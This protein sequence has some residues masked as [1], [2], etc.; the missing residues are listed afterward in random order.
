M[1]KIVMLITV[2][3]LMIS[4]TV[5]A[6]DTTT[7]TEGTLY[8]TIQNES[9][10]ITGCFG[11]EEVV[12]VPSSI[13][14]YPVNVIGK[15]AFASNSYVKEVELPDTITQIE[16]GAFSEK[17][18]VN[19]SKSNVPDD[20]KNNSNSSAG[21]G[22]TE[23]TGNTEN[24]SANQN[25]GNDSSQNNEVNVDVAEIELEE[26]KDEGTSA[27]TGDNKE[28]Q[29]R[30]ENKEK[31]KET[32]AETQESNKENSRNSGENKIKY[33]V[34]MLVVLVVVA[35]GGAVYLKCSKRK[36]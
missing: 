34:I 17:I 24:S 25:S 14:G 15:N 19:Y 10:T 32:T 2:A 29:D 20:G 3:I 23:N 28:T 21:A 5:H 7:Y 1:K 35:T 4:G 8:Y 30:K 36:R 11:K 31:D 26:R 16:K 27:E 13:A 18:I 9:I 33:V 12:K 22:S 6:E